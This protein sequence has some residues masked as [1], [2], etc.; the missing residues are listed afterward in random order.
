VSFQASDPDP[1]S[2]ASMLAI[3]VDGVQ[4][5]MGVTC[6]QFVQPLMEAMV[7]EPE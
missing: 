1:G 5:R 3:C 7:G 6:T 2:L 4:G